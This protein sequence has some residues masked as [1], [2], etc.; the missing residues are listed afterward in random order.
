[1]KGLLMLCDLCVI[2]VIANM[3]ATPFAIEPL[4][5]LGVPDA[6]MVAM[7]PLLI[8]IAALMATT[9]ALDIETMARIDAK[10]E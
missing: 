8:W 6:G 10:G 7:I 5:L 3:I 4:I 2:G 1:M 9:I